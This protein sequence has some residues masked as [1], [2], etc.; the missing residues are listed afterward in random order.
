MEKRIALFCVLAALILGGH[1]ALT[2]WL[3]PPKPVEQPVAEGPNE[4]GQ[5]GEKPVGKPAGDAK[6]APGESDAGKPA[7]A[8]AKPGEPTKPSDQPGADKPADPAAKP[9]DS[10]KPNEPAKPEPPAAPTKP[11]PVAQRVALGSLDPASGYRLLVTLTNQGAALE[12]IEAARS[13]Y[14]EL[15]EVGA[16]LG[17][18]A[19]A[20]T[21]DGVGGRVTV[22][23]RGTPAATATCADAAVAPGLQPG[24][25]LLEAG[26]AKISSD[27]ALDNVLLDAQPGQSLELVVQRGD[28]RLQFTAKLTQRPAQITRPEPHRDEPSGRTPPSLVMS[29]DTLSTGTKSSTT[30][31]GATEVA[32]IPS[33]AV[34]RW[35]VVKATED[36]AEFRLTLNE[37]A[38]GAAGHSGSLEFIKRFTLAKAATDQIDSE[39]AHAYHLQLELEVR[40]TGDASRRVAYRLS[41]V[42][43]L[44]L[45]GWWYMTKSG[46]RD[47]A[48]YTDGGGLDWYHAPAIHKQA[49]NNPDDPLTRLFA[50]DDRDLNRRVRFIGV[51]SQYFAAMLIPDAEPGGGAIF[52]SATAMA[53]S[54]VARI[55][56]GHNRTTNVGFELVS[57]L[58]EITP[59]KP[60]KQRF[61]LFAGPKHPELLTSYGSADAGGENS[62]TL[63]G[64]NDYGWF[65]WVSR[66]LSHVLHLFYHLTGNYGVAIVMLTLLVRS[67]ML[68]ISH[69]ATKNAQKMQELSPE[70]KKLAEKY[71]DDA[72]KRM[73]AQQD[74]FRQHN[75][76]PF[77]GCLLALCQLPIFIGLYRCLSL[78]IELRGAALLPGVAWCADLSAPDQLLYW[79]D[80]MPDWLAGE[81][82]YLGPY[83]NVLP[84]ITVSLF[85]VNQKLMTPP[86][87]DEQTR[88]QQQIMKFMTVFIGVMFFKVAGGLCLYFIASSLWSLAEHKVLRKGKK[89][90]AAATAARG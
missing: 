41:G 31:A 36:S 45:E 33:L 87:T 23:G 39:Y 9:S 43:S 66:P 3:N 71:K 70:L 80:F 47:V 29:L 60:L 35:E 77:G 79:K 64:L 58:A 89:A 88:M 78:D 76:N 32:G 26:G 61:T 13:H 34:G 51:D 12:R 68:P 50:Q 28:R 19:L 74:L 65:G 6:P 1:M 48:I 40:T 44:P 25:I 38:L 83:L 10:A 27:V 24:D 86:A 63:V 16:Y 2:A 62:Y 7:S 20:L 59:D 8:D 82:G 54:D 22:V 14:R 57:E 18:V 42:H 72:Q 73:K 46:A 81:T 55:D 53:V 52:R 21:S 56:K 84:L 67:C 11:E 4:P 37:D 75:Y 15:D 17:H 5:D 90:A 49:V 30:I 69:R 85:L